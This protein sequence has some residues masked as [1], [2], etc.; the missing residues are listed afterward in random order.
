MLCNT[1]LL[2]ANDTETALLNFYLDYESHWR[3]KS[4]FLEYIKYSKTSESQL[5][6]CN[7]NVRFSEVSGR[8]PNIN[9]GVSVLIL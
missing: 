6:A 8:L 3:R 5:F 9:M 1:T 4:F 7:L 2:K